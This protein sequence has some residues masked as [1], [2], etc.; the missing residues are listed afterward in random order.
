MVSRNRV[1]SSF[2]NIGDHVRSTFT[3][4][5]KKQFQEELEL[6][7]STTATEQWHEVTGKLPDIDLYM[8]ERLGSSAVGVCLAIC[9]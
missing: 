2:S 9:E 7:I 3:E 8:Q 1:I 4:R 6:W 5:Q